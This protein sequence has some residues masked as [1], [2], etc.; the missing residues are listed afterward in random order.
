[1][2]VGENLA[3]KLKELSIKTNIPFAD[4]LW[5]YAAEDMIHRIDCS[6]NGDCLW[7]SDWNYP[8][9]L[10]K[11]NNP[12]LN[13][14]FKKGKKP[15]DDILT[16]IL[17]LKTDMIWELID[18]GS[19]DE[20]SITWIFKA[21]YCSYEVSFPIIIRRIEDESWIFPTAGV[22]D[23]LRKRYVQIKYNALAVE[24]MLGQQVFEVISKLE[25]INNMEAY[26]IINDFLKTNSVSG[27]HMIE[28]LEYFI[29][30]EPKV[31]REKRIDQIKEYRSYA[32]MRK[33]WNQYCKK[34]EISDSW[35]EALDRV[36]S[37]IEPLW[38]AICNN[39]I[40]FDD[41]M[42]ELGRFLG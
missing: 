29:K 16:D 11:G 13:L 21:D 31:A 40:F 6:G 1:M 10:T 38:R 24:N 22:I 8:S 34:H 5:Q 2:K 19:K 28:E 35:E 26:A 12:K 4:L 41:W 9:K 37:F 20:K 15:L 25:L 14:L 7:L 33:R 18:E 27:R 36:A 30:R 32:Y 39:E 17:G 42:P 23:P 3:T